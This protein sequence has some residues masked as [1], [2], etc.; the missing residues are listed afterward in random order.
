MADV[1]IY[2]YEVVLPGWREAHPDG[3]FPGTYG[4]EKTLGP[5]QIGG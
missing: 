5:H 3:A 1:E 2:E 4:R